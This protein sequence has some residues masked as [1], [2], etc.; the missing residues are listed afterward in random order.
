MAVIQTPSG[1]MTVRDTRKGD[2]IIRRSGSSSSGRMTTRENPTPSAGELRGTAAEREEQIRAFRR[3]GQQEF[4]RER[5]RAEARQAAEQARKRQEA[6]QQAEV[7]RQQEIQRRQQENIQRT[8][9]ALQ[10][11]SDG[12]GGRRGID[13]GT[14]TRAP[15][16]TFLQRI[17]DIPSRISEKITR[18]KPRETLARV[19][20]SGRDVSE[21]LTAGKVAVD[22]G[23]LVLAGGKATAILAGAGAG[24]ITEKVLPEGIDVKQKATKDKEFTVFTPQFGTVTQEAPAGVVTSTITQKGREARTVKILTPELVREGVEAGTGLAIGIVTPTKFVAP[25]L[26]LGG[27][28]A[29]LDERRTKRERVIGVAEAGLGTFVGSAALIKAARAPVTI[30]KATRGAVGPKALEVQKVKVID[31][32]PEV[33]STF[34]RTTEVRPPTEVIRTTKGRVLFGLEPKSVVKKDSK[35]VTQ[36]TPF[37]VKIK[38]GEVITVATQETGKRGTKISRIIQ[39]SKP[40]TRK[41]IAELKKVEKRL[42]TELGREGPVSILGPGKEL[43]T[44]VGASRDVRVITKTPRTIR[45]KP[46]LDSKTSK[47]VAVSKSKKVADV[48][49]A[50]VFLT[51]GAASAPTKRAAITRGEAVIIKLTGK[52]SKGALDISRA[53]TGAKTKKV[54]KEVSVISDLVSIPKVQ[55][56]KKP[57][58]AKSKTD[59]P[60]PLIISKQD[61]KVSVISEQKPIVKEKDVSTLE[62]TSDI[63]KDVTIIKTGTSGRERGPSSVGL[64]VE[65]QKPVSDIKFE[66]GIKKDERA[67]VVKI[68]P[69]TRKLQRPQI[70]ILQQQRPTATR[71]RDPDPIFPIED[72]DSDAKRKVRET[73][74]MIKGQ[75]DVFARR[76]GKDILIGKARTEKEAVKKLTKKLKKSIAA[77][78]FIEVGGKKIDVN[79]LGLTGKEFRVSKIDPFRLVQRKGKRLGR[80]TEVEEIQLFKGSKGKSL[81]GGKKRGP[82][83]L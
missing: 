26:V 64:I 29:A 56:V 54:T 3:G 79:D 13:T 41:G 71:I 67:S 65:K 46:I 2:V 50:Q 47:V 51:E 45:D 77:S 18:E 16:R 69:Q 61:K 53:G 1:P 11:R 31:K 35:I 43:T 74:A 17:K 76:G 23:G 37:P 55:K 22:V 38:T 9:A 75:F 62:V 21:E 28:Q 20:G 80:K 49:G 83:L 14:I 60:S 82:S 5:K 30:T 25:A 40:T 19:T 33:F 8:Q 42:E 7:K 57:I 58:V 12:R 63:K 78:G 72:I 70:E 48:E 24:K 34:V 44:T 27:T 52:E 6:A 39:E 4:L 66:K 15:D 59:I 68:T 10:Q 36:F 81:F 32:K 73:A